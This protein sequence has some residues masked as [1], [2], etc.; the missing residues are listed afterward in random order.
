MSYLLDVNTIHIRA[1]E[2]WKQKIAVHKT[3]QEWKRKMFEKD[4]M[5]LQ[6]ENER[7]AKTIKLTEKKCKALGIKR[8]Q[9]HAQYMSLVNQVAKPTEKSP[10]RTID[11]TNETQIDESPRKKRRSLDSHTEVILDSPPKSVPKTSAMQTSILIEDDDNDTNKF[12]KVKPEPISPPRVFSSPKPR[13]LTAPKLTALFDEDEEEPP[14]PVYVAPEIDSFEDAH[15]SEDEEDYEFM[16][17]H[18]INKLDPANSTALAEAAK[19]A[20]TPKK[21]TKE[22]KK[23]KASTDSAK[24]KEVKKKE[25]ANSS[26]HRKERD[27]SYYTEKSKSHKE[28]R[29]TSTAVE[30][31]PQTEEI[32]I[33]ETEEEIALRTAPRRPPLSQSELDKQEKERLQEEIKSKLRPEPQKKGKS[34]MTIVR[35]K[36]TET[37]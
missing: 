3:T 25:K 16:Y 31:Q 20:S 4:Q 34:T 2:E 28:K 7:L 19:E 36:A 11:E 24:K 22:K 8:E 5:Y 13:R 6:E 18:G 37:Q 10:K 1:V 33:E 26:D 9:Y 23:E 15:P 32:H 14:A 21:K 35:K 17:E 12:R 30:V 29:S 27:I